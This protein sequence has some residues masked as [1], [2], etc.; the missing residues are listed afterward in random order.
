MTLTFCVSYSPTYGWS[1]DVASFIGCCMLI[2]ESFLQ[3]FSVNVKSFDVMVGT[4]TQTYIDSQTF[5]S[6]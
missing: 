1:K 5:F 6:S 4:L 2:C 3:H